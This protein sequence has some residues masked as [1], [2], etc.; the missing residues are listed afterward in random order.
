MTLISSRM[1]FYW[2]RVFPAVWF[3]F[4]AFFVLT[5]LAARG[6]RDFRPAF[7]IIP[8]F[9]AVFGYFLMKKLVF[10]LVD[11]V[12]DDGTELVVKNRGHV[13]RIPFANI[14]NV[15]YTVL[16]NPPRVTLTLR[17][18]GRLGKE[19][20]FAPPVRWIPLSRSPIVDRLIE[21]IDAARQ[22]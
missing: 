11:E 9:M 7:L 6:G 20:T 3:G 15:S 18:P 8:L 21:R 17:T 5:V 10:D 14:M 4:L 22:R 2:K 19:V 1:A 13:E 12:W 16:S